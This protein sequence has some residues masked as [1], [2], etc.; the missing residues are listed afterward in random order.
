MKSFRNGGEKLDSEIA[1]GRN[2]SVTVNGFK[3]GNGVHSPLPPDG[4][5]HVS[6]NGNNL[7]AALTDKVRMAHANNPDLL[8]PPPPHSMMIN[9]KNN[10]DQTTVTTTMM[11]APTND[12]G[13][14]NSMHLPGRMPSSTCV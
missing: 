12:D 11:T 5:Y 14:F 6:E 7:A 10:E 9:I 13:G 8:P 4:M 2:G 1:G 3:N